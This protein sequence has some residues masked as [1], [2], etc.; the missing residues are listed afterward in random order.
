MC[1]SESLFRTEARTIPATRR[2]GRGPAPSW[3]SLS[4]GLLLAAESLLTQGQLPSDDGGVWLMQTYSGL[5]PSV[6][7]ETTLKG[8]WDRWSLCSSWAGA[9]F[10]L[11]VLLPSLPSR[12]CS[13]GCFVIRNTL[14]AGSDS[15]CASQGTEL[16]QT[17]GGYFESL[18]IC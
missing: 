10:L 14:H 16:W 12:C 13:G 5:A 7:T 1:F 17:F 15:Q 6:P 11:P 4:G 18:S 8:Q 2:I 9:Q 3:V